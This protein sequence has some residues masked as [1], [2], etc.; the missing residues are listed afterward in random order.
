MEKLLAVSVLRNSRHWQRRY[1]VLVNHLDAW[2][3]QEQLT[4]CVL[5]RGISHANDRQEKQITEDLKL[6]RVPEELTELTHIL[7]GILSN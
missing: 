7:V 2:M 6:Y 4:N 1:L 3:L 5:N